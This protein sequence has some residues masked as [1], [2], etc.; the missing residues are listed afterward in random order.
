MVLFGAKTMSLYTVS[1]GSRYYACFK[2]T[3][4]SLYCT[5]LDGGKDHVLAHAQVLLLPQGDESVVVALQL[6][7]AVDGLRVRRP[8]DEDGARH[9]A[10][11]PAA[12]AHLPAEHVGVV[13]D[14]ADLVLIEKM[15]RL[16]KVVQLKFSV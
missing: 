3:E 11:L 2:M 4:K 13:T 8:Q 5:D 1:G 15:Y 16:L 10:L 14:G 7:R 6:L 12:V 9:L